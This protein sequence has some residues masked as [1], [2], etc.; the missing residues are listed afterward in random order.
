[1]GGTT[2][3][4]D[5]NTKR[6][7]IECANF[8]MFSIRRTSM[9]H[10]LFTDAVTR[11]TKGQS[12]FQS[13]RVISKA[14]QMMS[15]LSDAT[16]A[17]SVIDQTSN[18]ESV[19]VDDKFQN[20][21]ISITPDYINNRLGSSYGADEI[22]NILGNV[23]FGIKQEDDK[24]QVEIPFWRM[25][26][27][28]REDIVEEV[29]R[30]VGYDKLQHQ[31]PK[32]TVEP[33]IVD[34]ILLCKSQIRHTLASYGANEVLTYSFVNGKLLVKTDQDTEQAFKLSNALSPDLQYYRVSL[35][36]SLLNLVHQN[37]KSG[38]DKFALFE[39]GKVH[40]KSEVDTEGVPKEFGRVALVVADKSA[41]TSAFYGA[42]AYVN[43]LTYGKV[44]F[45]P[46]DQNPHKDHV[47]LSQM[48]APFE[49]SRTALVMSQE[50][51]LVGVVGEYKLSVMKAFKLPAYCGGAELF[52]N[53]LA[54]I[55]PKEYVPLSSYPSIS[56]DICLEVSYDKLYAEVHENIY[57]AIESQAGEV[58][59]DL[60]LIDIFSSPEISGKKRITFRVNVFSYERTLQEDLV[61]KL[62]D[63]VAENMANRVGSVRI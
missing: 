27:H 31:L 32:K 37:I 23:E 63:A 6:I 60:Q 39:L 5:S 59:V 10:G 13:D 61:S 9:A 56:Q 52:L 28:I 42:Q 58:Q 16:Q 22:S 26:I 35:T 41:N 11:F 18:L 34:P 33:A 17:S 47:M 29:A 1:M 40:G 15:E 36:P 8:D 12:P 48:L 44:K 2:T 4:V 21:M 45:I 50:N 43:E 7:I 30:L 51:K 14:M 38:T 46:I 3:E 25:D 57:S 55:E 24:I 20:L 62:L 54:S 53:S 49:P 19:V